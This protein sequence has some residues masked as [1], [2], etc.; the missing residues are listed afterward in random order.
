MQLNIKPPVPARRRL[1]PSFTRGCQ[2]IIRCSD[3]VPNFAQ[4]TSD[5]AFSPGEDG[6]FDPPSVRDFKGSIRSSDIVLNFASARLKLRLPGGERIHQALTRSAQ[7]P[8]LPSASFLASCGDLFFS[9]HDGS[10]L[11]CIQYK[12][13]DDCSHGECV[14]CSPAKAI[15]MGLV[16]KNRSRTALAGY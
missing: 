3:I 8:L 11:H 14:N 1:W 16:S 13:A 6:D 10:V 7:P 5:A 15:K 2:G 9:A 12:R 4:F